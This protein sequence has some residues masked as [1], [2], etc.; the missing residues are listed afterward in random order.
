MLW[1]THRTVEWKHLGEW[2]SAHQP[3]QVQ[4]VRAHQVHHLG[5]PREECLAHRTDPA[6]DKLAL[7]RSEKSNLIQS[8]LLVYVW[9]S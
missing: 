1:P 6:A 2:D 5:D 3:E 8:P 7:H 9:I 4:A